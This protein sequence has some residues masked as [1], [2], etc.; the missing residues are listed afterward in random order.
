MQYVPAEEGQPNIIIVGMSV[1]EELPIV[2]DRRR[3]CL[4]QSQGCP[5]MVY[6]IR[7]LSDIILFFIKP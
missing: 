2:D 3:S 4:Y 7:Q 6:K 5:V 1:A